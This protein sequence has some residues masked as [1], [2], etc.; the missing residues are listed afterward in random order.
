MTSQ[1]LG[2]LAAAG[3]RCCSERRTDVHGV[4]SKIRLRQSMRFYMKNNPAKLHPDPI[5]NDGDVGFFEVGRPNSKKTKKNKD[6]T[7]GQKIPRPSKKTEADY[8]PGDCHA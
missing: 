4:M 8:E 6:N 7:P 2:G 1:A 5:W 3:G